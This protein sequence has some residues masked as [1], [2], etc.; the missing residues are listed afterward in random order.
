MIKLLIVVVL[1]VATKPAV[2]V[3]SR[4]RIFFRFDFYTSV[5]CCLR[6]I[7]SKLVRHALPYILCFHLDVFVLNTLSL[8]YVHIHM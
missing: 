4:F 6:K 1:V 2:A 8:V 5:C 3:T 7:F